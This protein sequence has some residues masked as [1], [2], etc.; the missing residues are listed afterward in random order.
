M[1]YHIITYG[2]QMNKSDSERIANVLE[3]LG[4]IPSSQSNKADLLILNICSVRQSA[5]DRTISK[6][7][8]VK[9]KVLIT[10]CI[11]RIAERNG[12]KML[13]RFLYET[14]LANFVVLGIQIARVFEEE[15]YGPEQALSFYGTYLLMMLG[16]YFIL[17]KPIKFD[18]EKI[19]DK[20]D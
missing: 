12:V 6:A 8:P 13:G 19:N 17:S 20:V 3:N 18:E 11:V 10:G 16:F 7:Q 9:S 4:F 2:C 5:I 15:G 1:K 14:R